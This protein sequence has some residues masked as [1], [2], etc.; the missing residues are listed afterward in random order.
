V[1]DGLGPGKKIE[2]HGIEFP[3]SKAGHA[4]NWLST[5]D[6]NS[7]QVKFQTTGN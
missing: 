3:L 7:M 5:T 4:K 2:E 1:P 6:A